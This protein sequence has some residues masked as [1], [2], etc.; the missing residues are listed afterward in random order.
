MKTL[1]NCE[2]LEFFA[3]TAK[4]KRSVEKWLTDTDIMKIR[5]RRPKYEVVEKGA[6]AE[7]RKAVIE[8][9][10]EKER[11]QAAANLSAMFDAVFEDHPSETL[12][13]IALC[14]FIDP[15]DANKHST[16][17]YLRA[18]NELMNDKDVLDFFTSLMRLAR[19]NTQ[20]A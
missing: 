7:E 1:A 2:P 12:E 18:A 9:N 15:A 13:V 8:R 17:E 5:A 6:T 11:A 10:A 16:K 4:I 19:M 20:N 14:C 3:Q